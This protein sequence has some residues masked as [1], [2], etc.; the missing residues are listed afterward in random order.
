MQETTFPVQ[1]LV[2]DDASTDGT[3]AI[4]REYAERYPELIVA[5]LQREN[6]YSKGRRPELGRLQPARYLA[7][8]EGDDYWIVP[9][10]LERQIAILE[11]DPH[12]VLVGARAYLWREGD[13][14][15]YAIDPRLPPEQAAA[16]GPADFFVRGPWMHTATRVWRAAFFEQFLKDVPPGPG[17]FDLGQVLYTTA[18]ALRG[19]AIIRMLDS[20]TSVYRKHPGGIYSG[21]TA[22]W[23]AT[24]SAQITSAMVGFFPAGR[25]R[26]QLSLQAAGWLVAVSRCS[27]EASVSSRVRWALRA[28]WLGRHR[29]LVLLQHQA[30]FAKHLLKAL[31]SSRDPRRDNRVEAGPAGSVSPH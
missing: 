12:C 7:H 25:E 9:D 3:A 10:K 15:P 17:R 27:P 24:V 21:S 26:R 28:A 20:I 1:I 14:Q 19:K 8:C 23:D 30:R 4:V 6:L 2:H 16:L 11:M 29:P 31:F 13:P 5:V 18:A 22:T